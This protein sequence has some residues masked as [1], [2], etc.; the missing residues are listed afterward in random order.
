MAVP[1]VTVVAVA[2][3]SSHPSLAR[4]Q[5]SG[6]TTSTA[7]PPSTAASPTT[8]AVPPTT[9]TPPPG[10]AG[11]PVPGGFR[12]QSVTF[13]SASVGWVLGTGSC[14]APPCTS[15]VRTRDG[16]RSW[17]GIPAPAVALADQQAATG[18]STVRFADALD[19]WVFGPDLWSTHDGGG[20]WTRLTLPAAPA[21]SAV[22]SLETS[23]G[24]AYALT[25][26]LHCCAPAIVYGTAAASD[27]WTAE[28][29]GTVPDGEQGR[30]VAHGAGAWAV[31]TSSQ[32]ASTL[33]ARTGGGWVHRALPCAAPT[34]ALAT[35]SDTDLVAVCGGQGAAGSQVKQLYLSHDGGSTF[36]TGGRAPLSGDL[37]GIGA[38]APSTVVVAA[39]SGASFL[40]ASFDG[41]SNWTTVFD[42]TSSGGLPW[43]DLGFTDA[44]QGVVVEGLAVQ[45]VA[46][47]PPSR[48]LLTRDGGHSWSPVVF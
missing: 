36:A 10:P 9:T 21:A 22:V 37:E 34:D 29:G 4:R 30:V 19:G 15:L 28:P 11:G 2:G 35:W 45:Q 32:G 12:P 40:H 8:S 39:A 33:L 47:Q 38:A 7:S 26:P 6:T 13:V 16:G 17:R 23:G 25:V 5:A 24:R 3:C 14:S 27:A 31:V 46:G 1:V 42:D 20:H 18:V 43:R 44:A 41:G 48:L